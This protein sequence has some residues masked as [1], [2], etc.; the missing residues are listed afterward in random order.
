MKPPRVIPE[1]RVMPERRRER[2]QA[3]KAQ[4]KTQ[5][6]DMSHLIETDEIFF[7]QFE[8]EVERARILGKSVKGL[9]PVEADKSVK[10][11]SSLP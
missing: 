1:R 7:R 4:H 6:E 9:L 10:K 5:T 3:Q 11:T 8:E 2:V